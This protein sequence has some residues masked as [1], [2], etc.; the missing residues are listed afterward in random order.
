MPEQFSIG[1]DESNDI[2]I[3]HPYVSEHHALLTIKDH[4]NKKFH[5]QDL[6]TT[7]GTYKNDK[8][9]TEVDFTAEDTIKL[10]GTV[11]E[12]STLLSLC[13]TDKPSGNSKS[14]DKKSKRL[15]TS[16]SYSVVSIALITF[17]LVAAVVLVLALNR[18]FDVNLL[19]QIT[20]L[21]SMMLITLYLTQA[22][23]RGRNRLVAEKQYRQLLFD[24]WQG[25]MESGLRYRQD[26]D[27]LKLESWSGYRKFRVAKRVEEAEGIVSFYLAPHDQ[28]KLAKFKP[29]QYL[30]FQLNIPGQDKPVI[31]CYSLSDRFH[32]DYYRVSIKKIPPPPKN[33]ALPPGLSSSYFHE[34]LKAESI[35]DVKAPSGKF[36]LNEHSDAGVI[37]I[38]GGVGLTPMIS[39]INTLAHQ[40]SKRDIWFFYGVRNGVE[41]AM[42]THL[43]SLDEQYD[44]VHMHLCFSNPDDNDKHGEDYQHKERVSV[45]LF[46]KLLPSNNFEYYMCGPPPMMQSVTADLEAWGVPDKDI[47]Y[48]AF[49]PASVKKKDTSAEKPVVS[50]QEIFVE[51]SK[52]GKK[53][54]WSQDSGSILEFAENNGIEM[55]FGCRAGNCGTCQVAI[56]SGDVRYTSEHDVDVEKGSCLAC[57]SVP[58]NNI[59]LDA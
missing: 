58:E 30:T 49:G 44:N 46:K 34:Q 45:E 53:V 36:Y 32:D 41:L 13:L 23:M 12:P 54:A 51:F 57:I 4:N 40:K 42:K 31:R 39:M 29:G 21:W 48:E 15:V 47:Y 38:A 17:T 55:S 9:I 33:P 18:S 35:V 22:V 10:A 3:S 56:R 14:T 27:D 7:N 20:S 19:L 37:L 1:R 28:K 8:R 43:K 50:S 59:V 16:A 2:V 6:T 11:L 26:E 24:E 52:S 5:I 25:K